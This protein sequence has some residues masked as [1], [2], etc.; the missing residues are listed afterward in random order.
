MKESKQTKAQLVAQAEVLRRQRAELKAAQA[1]YQQTQAALQVS[2]SRYRRLFETAQDGILILDADTGQITDVNPFLLKLLGYSHAELLGRRLWEIGPF[3]DIA[4]AQAAFSELQ[5]KGYI[6]YEDLPLETRAG[7]SLHVEFVSNVYRVDQQQVIQC[8]IR[9]ITA[10]KRAEAA[11]GQS[12]AELRERNEELDAFAHTVAHD[13][14]N[15]VH[16]TMGYADLLAKYYLT[17]S[18][19]ERQ[20][21]LKVLVLTGQK[22]GKIIDELLLLAELHKSEVET[23]PL[24]MASIVAESV[25]RLTNDIKDTQAE[26]AWPDVP[27]W[28]AALG[29]GP[30]VE[31]VW[32][33]Y[34][35]NALKYGGTPLTTP[36]IELGAALQRDGMGCYWVRD[37]GPG[38]TPE[39]QSRLFA[40]FT[41][42]NQVRPGG[43]GLGLSIVRRI[44]ERLGGQAG[45]KSQVG[46]GSLFYFTLPVAQ[47]APDLA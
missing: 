17:M 10:R 33:N 8:N 25:G 14:K 23:R 18:E 1:E 16:L 3:K 42:L 29:Y 38:I 40:P 22:M 44:V 30:W 32:I 5:A 13:L 45:L 28:P 15:P 20:R 41:R 47:V 12:L 7:Q 4:A 43:H 36:R 19:A 46:E 39:T 9:D 21:S 37:H 26:I 6:R 35:S 27:D 11:L 34:L 24:D 31:E 2:E